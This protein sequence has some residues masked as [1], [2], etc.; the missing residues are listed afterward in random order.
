METLLYFG[1]VNLYWILLFACYQLM[2]RNHTFFKWNRYYLL[3]S[4]IAAFFLPLLIYPEN[5]PA[6]PVVYQVNAADFTVRA[7]EAEAAPFMTWTQIIWTIYGLGF[8][9][10]VFQFFKHIIQLRKFLKAGEIIELDDCTVVLIDSNNTGSFSFLN[11]IVINRNDYEH[12]FDAILRHEMVHTQQMHSLDILLIEILK[13]LFWFNPFLLLYKRSMQEIHE[14]LAD[15]QAPNRDNYARFLVAY[16]LKAP[17]T[18]LTN[19]FF[20]PSQIKNRIRMIYKNRTSKWMLSTYLF[21]LTVI[22]STA[23]FVAGC[24]R[25]EQ[26]EAE[27]AAR[28]AEKA[29]KDALPDDKI[30]SVVEEQPEFPGGQQAMFQFLGRKIKYP[31]AAAN[32]NV[33]G[34]VFLQFVVTD[35]GNIQD[36]VVLKGIGYGC[37]A[38]SVR[39]LKLFPKWK[40]GKQNGKPV[41]VKFT[42]PVNFQLEESDSESAT[43]TIHL[44]EKMAS[45]VHYAFSPLYI[46][47]GKEMENADFLKKL[48]GEK[49][50]SMDV[51]KGEKA[52]EV[53]GDK[54][55]NGVIKITTK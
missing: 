33:Q 23:L 50:K 48:P 42:L 3:G 52:E 14:F 13:V 34:K 16:A 37:D 35:E 7:N 4:L 8:L 31:T 6:I 53:Y 22:A 18:S 44:D 19:H 12:H 38:E 25:T 1:K 26:N 27:I 24:E 29:T 11:W 20:K 39:V 55:K 47:D 5:A 21:A 54:G 30:F 43:S 49:I 15:A 17:I 28:N 41:N 40:P 10:T 36:I 45:V 46:L 9:V 2:L 51:L 32:A